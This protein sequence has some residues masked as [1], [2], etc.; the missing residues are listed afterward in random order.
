[1]CFFRAITLAAR[2][3]QQIFLINNVVLIFL[4]GVKDVTL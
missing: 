1:M 2:C 4:G 3:E